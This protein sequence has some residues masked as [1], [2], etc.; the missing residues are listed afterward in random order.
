MPYTVGQIGAGPSASDF[1]AACVRSP[2]VDRVALAAPDGEQRQALLDRYGIIKSVDDD[3][4][5][6]LAHPE[7]LLVAL[8]VPLAEQPELASAAL[9]AGKHVICAGPLAPTLAQ[10]DEM[11]AVAAETSR[12]LLP[13]LHEPLLPAHARA[14][15]LLHAGEIGPPVLLT[16]TALSPEPP[17]EPLDAVV[18]PLA[19]LEHLV[20]PVSAITASGGE[21]TLL[22]NLEFATGV[23]GQVTLCH[24]AAG[25]RPTQER[26]IVGTTGS[27][28]IRDNPEDEWPLI[29]LATDEFHPVKVTNPPD[30]QAWARREAVCQLIACA[31]QGTPEL[32]G[33]PEA[34]SALATALAAM[35]SAH[36]GQRVSL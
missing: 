9:R 29:F 27:L 32:V 4:Q 21:P 24:A 6:L 35:E 15:A 34:R 16:V 25:D 22:L 33:L 18:Q 19:L 7:V 3:Y 5:E 23:V 8:S 2:H 17:P 30:I 14:Q 31:V 11:V 13:V 12:R 36:T 28:L 20:G 1:V 10:A 26:R